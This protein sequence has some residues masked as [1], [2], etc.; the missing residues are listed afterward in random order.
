MPL[1]KAKAAATSLRVERGVV[2]TAVAAGVYGRLQNPP[3]SGDVLARINNIRPRD[4]DHIGLLLDRLKPGDTV[5]FVFL[6][7]KDRVATRVDM[8]LTLSK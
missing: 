5:H 4:L 8:T 3:Q 1:S 6:R 2:I 7:M